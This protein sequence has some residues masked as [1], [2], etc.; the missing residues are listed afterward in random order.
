MAIKTHEQIFKSDKKHQTG[1]TITLK[2]L[3]FLV[4]RLHITTLTARVISE[5]GKD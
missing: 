1:P 3:R 5:A 2:I 4:L